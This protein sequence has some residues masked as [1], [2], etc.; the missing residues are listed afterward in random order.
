MV[1]T[2]RASTDDFPAVLG[3]AR[4]AL[5]WSD[6]DPGFLEW[7]HQRNAFGVSPMWVAEDDGRVVGFRAFLR[8]ELTAPDGHVV[9]AVRAVDTATAPEHQGRGIFTR[10]TSDALADLQ[11]EGVELVFNTPNDKSLPGYLKMGWQEVGRLPAVV[12]PARWRFPLVVATARRPAGRDAVTTDVGEPAAAAL[13]PARAEEIAAVLSRLPVVQGL[14]TRHRPAS[15]AWRFG[16]PALGYRVVHPGALGRGFVVFRLRRR[17]AAVEAVVS[18]VLVPG[19]D[20]AVTRTLLSRVAGA[21]ADYLIRLGS[22]GVTAPAFVR[23]PRMG[24]ILVGR[25]LGDRP[26]P[27]LAGWA[28]TMGDVELL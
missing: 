2:R 27:P 24:P 15:L 25:A 10:L 7:K 21:G 17:G 12:R 26:V 16:E 3:L 23:L 18:E 4:A 13:A 9:R 14:R 1:T 20:A 11:A 5:G 28:L 6:G 8:W 22:D 19:G